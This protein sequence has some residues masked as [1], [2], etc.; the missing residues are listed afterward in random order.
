MILEASEKVEEIMRKMRIAQNRQKKYADR[1]RRSL[2]FAVGDRIF[3]KIS[4]L[5]N[6]IRFGR[7]GKLAPRFIGPFRILDRAGPLAYKIDLPEKLVRVHNVFHVSH[8]RK[9]LPDPALFVQPAL[10]ETLDVELN[11]TVDRKPVRIVD[12]GT[13]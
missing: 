7:K 10:L 12:R 8:L 6:V 9:Y 13:K 11:L 5:K 3:L 1:C 2:E 4:P